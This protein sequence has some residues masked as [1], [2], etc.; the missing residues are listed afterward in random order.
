MLFGLSSSSCGGTLIWKDFVLSAAHCWSSNANESAW[1]V[2]EYVFIGSNT[3]QTLTAGSEKKT[4][5]RVFPFSGYNSNTMQNDYLLIQLSSVVQSTRTLATYNGNPSVPAAGQVLTTM[6]FGTT[7]SG[8]TASD[9][10]LS[11][12]VPVVA[13]TTCANSY[14]S[15]GGAIYAASMFCAGL[16]GKDSCQVRR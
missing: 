12:N 14:A 9:A 15:A 4:I 13:Q 3:S 10:F 16:T 6:G 8:G 2:G 1:V 5:R 11:V 7:S